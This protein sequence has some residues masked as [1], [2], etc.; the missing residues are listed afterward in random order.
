[1]NDDFE[2]LIELIRVAG[3]SCQEK[4][5]SDRIRTMLLSIGVPESNIRNDDAHLRSRYG[6]QVGNLIVDLP[7]TGTGAR[8]LLSTHMDTIV[9]AVG[10]DPAVEG[11]RLINRAKGHSLGA[12]ARA[13][14][15]VLIQA[16][17]ELL[18]QG[19]NHPPCT[20]AFFVQEELGLVGSRALDMSLL[21][22]PVP[23]MGFNFDGENPR[24]IVNTS[25]GVSRLYITVHGI[26]AHGSRPQ[27]G[28][29]AAEI[30]AKTVATLTDDGWH[31]AITKPEGKGTANLGVLRGGRMSNQVMPELEILMEARSFQGSFRD[32]IIEAWKSEFERT[33]ARYNRDRGQKQKAAVTFSAGPQYNPFSLDEHEPVV[34]AAKR[35]V[36]ACGL[37]PILVSDEGG[38][39][40]NSLVEA[41]LP[42]VGMGMGLYDAH[43]ED[44]WLDLEQYR[45]ACRIATFLCTR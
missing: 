45:T 41:G 35:A 24:E 42:S 1:V 37:E 10:S 44:E 2:R 32:R 43:Q 13:G 30:E 9:S 17:G 11:N 16:I 19:S 5:I 14:C 6:G 18:S 28:I 38:M 15:A 39:D 27:N 20:F 4:E 23:C 12:D 7:G 22:T 8:R 21:G 26:A 3:Q 29:S 34:V 25:I 36:V 40:T 33:V 31:G